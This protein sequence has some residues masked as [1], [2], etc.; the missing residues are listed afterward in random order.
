[1]QKANIYKKGD[2]DEIYLNVKLGSTLT[3]HTTKERATSVLSESH[4]I[5]ENGAV[6]IQNENTLLYATPKRVRPSYQLL[7]PS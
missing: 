4:H 6:P 1:M 3:P 7:L 5:I 2:R